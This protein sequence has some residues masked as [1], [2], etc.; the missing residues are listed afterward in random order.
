MAAIAASLPSLAFPLCA[1]SSRR[2]EA[3][4]GSRVNGNA[5]NGFLLA[6]GVICRVWK[7]YRRSIAPSIRDIVFARL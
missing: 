7:I 4:T 3:F 1:S 6:N 5:I 2:S